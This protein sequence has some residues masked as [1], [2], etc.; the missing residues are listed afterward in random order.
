MN[1]NDVDLELAKETA[2]KIRTYE[3][4]ASDSAYPDI[5]DDPHLTYLSQKEVSN[6]Y[7]TYSKMHRIES[8]KKDGLNEEEECLLVI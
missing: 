8:V 3:E 5:L 6:L 4:K 2:Q 7:K 1:N